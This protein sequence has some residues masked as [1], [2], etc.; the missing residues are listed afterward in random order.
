MNAALLSLVFFSVQAQQQL[1][2]L[3]FNA[4]APL[5][6]VSSQLFGLDLEF[7]RHDLF[8]GLSAQLLANRLFTVQPAG[9]SWPAPVNWGSAWPPRWTALPGP[10]GVNCTV[11]QRALPPTPPSQCMRCPDGS[12]LSQT[13][14]LGGFGSSAGAFGS[15]LGFQQGKNYT[16]V[17]VARV[18]TGESP[19]PQCSLS[20]SVRLH[21]PA[22]APVSLFSATHAEK[23]R[24]NAAP[25]PSDLWRG[26]HANTLFPLY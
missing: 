9:E 13:T 4:S 26:Q 19:L 20:V 15:A 17:V 8:A 10:G 16:L 1:P 24:P 7:T 21:C 18:F 3:V 6:T 5:D 14:T 2:D 12:G 25:A 11:C 22:K 23:N